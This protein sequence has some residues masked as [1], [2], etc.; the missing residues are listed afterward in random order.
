MTIR[1]VLLHHRGWRLFI[2]N[3]PHEAAGTALE[4]SI[5]KSAFPTI[6]WVIDGSWRTSLASWPTGS[7]S[8]SPSSRNVIVKLSERQNHRGSLL[9]PPQPDEPRYL[10][11]Q[12]Q[13]VDRAQPDGNLKPRAWREGKA[14]F[15]FTAP[16]QTRVLGIYKLCFCLLEC[17]KITYWGH[18]GTLQSTRFYFHLSK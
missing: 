11:L 13:L 17:Y 2:A 6:G 12:N 4:T 9:H 10:V 7:R 3:L 16:T 1:R 14:L 5:M 18:M 15:L 8:Y